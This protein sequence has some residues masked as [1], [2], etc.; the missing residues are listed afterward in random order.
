MYARIVLSLRTNY[1]A[2]RF[3]ERRERQIHQ[4]TDDEFPKKAEGTGLY[5]ENEAELGR[6]VTVYF[7]VLKLTC[8]PPERGRFRWRCSE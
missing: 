3:W 8:F 5:V 4:D 2:F 6:L 1:L 7:L